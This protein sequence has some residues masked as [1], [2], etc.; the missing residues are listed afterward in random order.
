M[1]RKIA[2]VMENGE[3]LH[4]IGETSVYWIFDGFQFRKA[5]KRIREVIEIPEETDT[6]SEETVKTPEKERPKKAK[7]DEE[8][9]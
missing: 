1:S 8:K 5:N 6:V 3:E 4:P 2:V 9:A 7:K